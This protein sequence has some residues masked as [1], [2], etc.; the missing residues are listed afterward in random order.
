[1]MCGNK[2]CHKDEVCNHRQKQYFCE[3]A[4]CQCKACKPKNTCGCTLCE[5]PKCTKASKCP[6][7]CLAKCEIA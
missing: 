3:C 4:T 7:K 2:K 5:C 1:M 6:G